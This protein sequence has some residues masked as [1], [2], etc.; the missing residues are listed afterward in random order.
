MTCLTVCGLPHSQRP[1]GC[2]PKVCSLELKGPCPVINARAPGVW[3]TH[4]DL[5]R[6]SAVGKNSLAIVPLSLLRQPSSQRPHTEVSKPRSSL[7]QASRLLHPHL[8]QSIPRHQIRRTLPRHVVAGTLTSRSLRQGQL[9]CEGHVSGGEAPQPFAPL[10]QRL[11][12]PSHRHLP[13]TGPRGQEAPLGLK[14]RAVPFTA[15]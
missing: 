3:S 1:V 4:G 2:K 10:P 6:S 7:G 11:A 15:H 5:R 8:L 12:V 9:S 14:S 13:A